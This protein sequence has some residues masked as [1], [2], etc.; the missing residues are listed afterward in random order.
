MLIAGPQAAIAQGSFVGASMAD[1]EPVPPV[2]GI[3]PVPPG[4]S[5][6]ERAQR[7]AQAWVDEVAVI[8]P[9]MS[10]WQ[11][12]RLTSPQA[13]HNPKGEVIAYMFAIERNGKIVGRVL[14]GSSAYGFPILEAGKSPPFP[15]PSASEVSAILREEHGLQIGEES[16]GE[17][18]LLLLNVLQ[19]FYAVWEV[20]G[21]VAGINLITGHSL[22]APNVR[23]LPFAMPCPVQYRAAK[24][25]TRQSLLGSAYWEPLWDWGQVLIRDAHLMQAWDEL[26]RLPHPL[27]EN[28]VI[29]GWCGPM[30]AVSIGVWKRDADG[31]G[32]LHGPEP[33]EEDEANMYAWLEHYM[34][35][36]SFPPGWTFPGDYGPGFVNYGASRGEDFTWDYRWTFS[37]IMSDIGNDWPL[38]LLGWMYV[39][40]KPGEPME[41][42]AHWVAVK[43]WGWF[44][45]SQ[46]VIV[47][48]SNTRDDE[49]WL[50]WDALNAP[51]V[52]YLVLRLIRIS[53]TDN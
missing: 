10:E 2:E 27:R 6:V 51:G 29:R 28:E 43:G 18:R 53:D 15:V 40:K 32:G 1:S 13:F 16:L 20:E 9:E 19:G 44:G 45:L 48:D 8:D 50:C 47:T 25:A 23:A 38:G 31:D 34:Q 41:K 14:V 39:Y 24:A 3:A 30:S 52:P 5:E 11:G 46:Y 17:A 7:R 12:A 37:D 4:E 42:A 26:A 21:R 35:T 22:T 36:L 49:R 33:G